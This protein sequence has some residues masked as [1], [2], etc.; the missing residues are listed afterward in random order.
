[1]EREDKKSKGTIYYALSFSILSLITYFHPEFLPFYGIG[2]LTMSLGDGLAP[3]IGSKFNR[4]Q[5]GNTHK[6]FSGSLT[7]FLTCL[8]TS[9]IFNYFYTIGF[10]LIA[11][12]VISTLAT[13]FELL[14]GKYDNLTLPLGTALI[15][16]IFGVYL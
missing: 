7:I 2:C 6:T 4:Y 9:L 13:I 5:I 16:F 1:M 3:F 14:G 11:Y 8:L 10:S 12:I 15:S